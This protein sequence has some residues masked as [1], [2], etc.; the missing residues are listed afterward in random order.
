MYFMELGI[1]QPAPS[2]TIM[3]P[4]Q[5]NSSNRFVRSH[6]PTRSRAAT[7]KMEKKK[8]GCRRITGKDLGNPRQ[9][10]AGS[11]NVFQGAIL[12]S[13]FKYAEWIAPKS[14]VWSRLL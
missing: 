7:L 9:N 11:Q 13:G 14:T 12:P 5:T 1:P 2:D 6:A 10:I 4:R 3:S 8:R